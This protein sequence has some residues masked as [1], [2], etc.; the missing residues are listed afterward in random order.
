MMKVNYLVYGYQGNTFMAQ[1]PQVPAG[2]VARGY[3][4]VRIHEQGEGVASAQIDHMKI[5]GADGDR[6]VAGRWEQ[7]MTS[8]REA[9]MW[10]LDAVLEDMA[11]PSATQIHLMPEDD[12][13]DGIGAMWDEWRLVANVPPPSED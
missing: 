9:T 11:E 13:P 2:A 10:L 1:V 6:L 4:C 7:E 5:L 8:W 12:A 3:I